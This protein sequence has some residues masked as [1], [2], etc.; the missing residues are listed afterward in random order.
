MLD[1]DQQ[2]TRGI[3]FI[4]LEG[5]LTTTNY[6]RFAEEVNYLLYSQGMLAYVFNLENIKKL[7]NNLLGSLQNKLTEIF[8]KCGTVAFCGLPEKIKKKMGKR[9]ALYYI[10]EEKEVL[11]SPRENKKENGKKRRLILYK[12]RK[13]SISIY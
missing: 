1:I 7:D 6:Y 9:D 2:I 11:W 5:E 8:L 10:K 12:R 13:R 4:R 3:T